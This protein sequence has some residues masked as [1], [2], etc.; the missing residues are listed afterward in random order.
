MI[1]KA[2]TISSLPQP[3]VLEAQGWFNSF[4]SQ[5]AMNL[6]RQLPPSL[7]HY[8]SVGGLQGIISSGVTLS[9][10]LRIMRLALVLA[11]RFWQRIRL[12]VKMNNLWGVLLG[13]PTK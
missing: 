2:A 11:R 4:L 12:K 1:E 13:V 10:S 6:T 5:E 7:Y 9:I 8:T 3:P